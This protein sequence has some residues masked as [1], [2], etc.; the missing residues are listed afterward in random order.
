[1]IMEKGIGNT[2]IVAGM[3][4]IEKTIIVVLSAFHFARKIAMV[5]PNVSGLLDMNGIAIVGFDFRDTHVSY[6]H[7][8]HS[9]NSQTNALEH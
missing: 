7:V 2:N 8:G 9:L 1:M 6:N 4:D 5:D 3:A